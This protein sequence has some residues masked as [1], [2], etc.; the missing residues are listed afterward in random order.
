M[1]TPFIWPGGPQPDYAFF[2]DYAFQ[3]CLMAG[4]MALVV[5]FVYRLSK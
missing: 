4:A 1:I 3:G 2:L 5:Y